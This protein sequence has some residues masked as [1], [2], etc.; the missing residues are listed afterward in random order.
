[1]LKILEL[2]ERADKINHI[3]KL[4]PLE[5]TWLV[6]DLNSKTLFQTILLKKHKCLTENSVLRVSELWQKILHQSFPEIEVVSAHFVSVLL[7]EWLAK[8][9][10]PWAQH[11]GT[12]KI[13][14]QYIAQF[15]PIL[16]RRDL[17][18]QMRD[19]LR[20]NPEALMRWG[21][22]FILAKEAW[23]FFCK[24]KI[25]ASTWV[26]A[27]LSAEE[28]PGQL[29]HQDIIVDIGA[30]IIGVEIELFRRLAKDVDVTIYAPEKKWC[31]KYNSTL[32]AYDIL[33]ERPLNSSVQLEESIFSNV[34]IGR[35]TT[36]IAEVKSAVAQIRSWLEQGAEPKQLAILAAD[37]EQYW[38][39]LQ[40]YLQKEGVPVAKDVVMRAASV[41]AVA[42][43]LA[44]IKIESHEIESGDLESSV[45]CNSQLPPI[46][47][48]KFQQLYN[49][50][51]DEDDLSRNE[52][53][54][55]IF[56]FKFKSSDLI[57]RED[58]FA[59]AIQFWTED[60]IGIDRISAEILKE[61]PVHVR[62]ELRSW[63]SYISAL[64]AKIEFK[65]SEGPSLGVICSNFDTAQNLDFKH[66]VMLG[67]SE[68]ELQSPS[69][70]SVTRSDVAKIAQDLGVYLESPDQR[71]NEF[72]AEKIGAEV[73]GELVL[74]F[75][76]T[77]FS[78]QA[79]APSL[80]W[81]KTA[82]S[83]QIDIERYNVPASTR[84]DEIQNSDLEKSHLA[85]IL[86]YM[87]EDVGVKERENFK[88]SKKLRFSASQLEKYTKCPFIFSAEK[89][90]GLSD[91]PDVDLDVDAMT[92]GRL[93]HAVLEQLL[94][95]PLNLSR[96]DSDLIAL[97]D[98]TKDSLA[99]MIGETRLWPAKRQH[100][101]RLA[102]N[103]LDF[104]KSWRAQYPNTYTIGKELFLSGQMRIRDDLEIE[105]SGRIDRVDT[106]SAGDSAQPLYVVLDYKSSGAGLH[107]YG[108]WLG[109]DEI[110]LTFYVMAISQGL[111][112]LPPGEV[113][114]AFY[115]IISKMNRERGFRRVDK[116]NLLFGENSRNRTQITEEKLQTLLGEVQGKIAEIV[117]KI[118][119]GAFQPEPK[120]SKD[121]KSCSWS[122]L[123]RA[124]HLN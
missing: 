102:K 16:V 54:Q 120:D 67:L 8:R 123:C 110:Q 45:F 109:N 1:M 73:Q 74:S 124:P 10:L 36:Q 83:N 39:S 118:T 95:E 62:L 26:S 101:L 107:N 116:L 48:E 105:V 79:Q 53:V 32:W 5:Q 100:Y 4:K 104:E 92:S 12:P 70:L 71:Y 9:D 23:E 88:S 59:W 51:Y 43:W 75:A 81:L 22:W 91:L 80:F 42:K 99:L 40:A 19:W 47:Y 84:W 121:C 34:I 72:L 90:F 69:E 11:P 115:Y 112:T 94:A 13:L 35:Y 76:V 122:T 56:Q 82:L 24:E 38:P 27:F 15:L 96:S 33:S 78:G 20:E 86:P 98:R 21:N 58:F 6:A 61:C 2:R 28:W 66:V 77:D 29:W 17:S 87:N 85:K 18:E 7:S 31:D 111:T 44:R 103:F 65:I 63:V 68:N 14:T 93:M 50:I 46:E 55:K 119:L 113:I 41:P 114:G 37:I 89:I 60:L 52:H 3:E 108:S 97:I 117:E 30:D 25:L 106:Y 49:K 57:S 64:V